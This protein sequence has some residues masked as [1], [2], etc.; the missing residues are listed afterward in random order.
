[1]EEKRETE[2][3]HGQRQKQAKTI[4][5]YFMHTI[6]ETDKGSYTSICGNKFFCRWLFSNLA[7]AWF[8]SDKTDLPL[9]RRLI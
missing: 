2:W 3:I 7:L 1:M 5:T 8:K 4:R 9:Q 6:Y